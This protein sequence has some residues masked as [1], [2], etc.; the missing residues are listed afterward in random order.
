MLAQEIYLLDLGWLGGDIGW[1]LPG[2]A[3]CA[4]TLSDRNPVRKW[5]EIP[6]SAVVV[7]HPDGTVLFDAGISPKAM[8][9]HEKGL[10]EA[11]PIVRMSEENRIEAQLA[12]IGLSPADIDFIV[13]SHLHLDHIGQLGPFQ[14]HDIPIIVQKHELESALYLLWQ[15]KGGAYDFADLEPLR[16]AKWSPIND[17]QFE[18]LD[19]VVLEWTGGHT[20]GHQVMHVKT[21]SGQFYTFTGDYLHIPQEYEI[22]A[23]GWLL[24]DAEEW[25]AY[26]R[27]LK[28]M[29]KARKSQLVL[30]HD[31]D[32]WKKYP[33][34][35]EP[36]A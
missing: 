33:V 29:Q 35:P 34:A 12:K 11:F 26:I 5:I 9:T 19:G 25:H 2:G 7:R 18:L 3:G 27:K 10:V 30:G 20:P 13:I 1:F 16:G 22:E 6:V 24:G 4:M 32:L 31:P 23:K 21:Q 28:V 14:T 36:L 8:Q 15:G 17:R